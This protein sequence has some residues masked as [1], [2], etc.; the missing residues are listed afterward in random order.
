MKYVI[1]FDL[2]SNSGPKFSRYLI[3]RE[4]KNP[5]SKAD[6]IFLDYHTKNPTAR[7]LIDTEM[8]NGPQIPIKTKDHLM[9]QL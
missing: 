6:C 4:R 1:I 7:L 3:I 2:S 9:L 8:D 5:I